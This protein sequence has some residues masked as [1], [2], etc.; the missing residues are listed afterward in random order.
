M[1]IL[2]NERVVSWTLW[3]KNITDN[4]FDI[5]FVP[6]NLEKEISF[7]FGPNAEFAY[8]Y[9]QCYE[10]STSEYVY[11]LALENNL[12]YLL[13]SFYFWRTK[14]IFCIQVHLQA[15]S[16]Q[17]SIPETQVWRIRN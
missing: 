12:L 14:F 13:L 16:V 17:Q 9:S 3:N 11:I 8:L 10:L 15:L 4:I 6:R 5:P 1:I 7:D 2:H